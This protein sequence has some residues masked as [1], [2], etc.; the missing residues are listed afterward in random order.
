[1]ELEPPGAGEKKA[2]DI[3]HLT[4]LLGNVSLVG[5]SVPEVGGIYVTCVPDLEPLTTLASTAASLACTL[6]PWSHGPLELMGQDD[7]KTHTDPHLLTVL[8]TY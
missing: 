4:T 6:V 2:T 8:Q 1:M 7:N 3:A 5:A